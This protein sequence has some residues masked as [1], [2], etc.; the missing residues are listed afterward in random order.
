MRAGEVDGSAGKG[1]RCQAQWPEFDPQNH[2]EGEMSH[3]GGAW[4]QEDAHTTQ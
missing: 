1:L 3:G 2:D 4:W